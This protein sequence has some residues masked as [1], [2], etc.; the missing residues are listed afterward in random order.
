M[1]PA[2]F[3]EKVLLGKKTQEMDVVFDAEFTGEGLQFLAQGAVAGDDEFGPGIGFSKKGKCPKAGG[4]AFF[5]DE[6]AGLDNAPGSI[7]RRVA[8]NE[9]DS[10]KERALDADFFGGTTEADQFPSQRF[11]P[12]GDTAAV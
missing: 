3:G 10:G 11:G 8:R 5:G 1:G 4:V 7:G 12:A 9:R 6:T 2:V